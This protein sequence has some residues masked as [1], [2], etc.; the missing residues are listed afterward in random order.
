MNA[1]TVEGDED[2]Q[3]IM[4]WVFGNLA[5]EELVED[6]NEEGDDLELLY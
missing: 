2:I 5:D 3:Y 6:N 4:G 1:L